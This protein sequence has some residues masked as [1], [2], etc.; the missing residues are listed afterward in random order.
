MQAIANILIVEDDFAI[1]ETI[2]ELL[3][4]EGYA[5]TRA[6]NGA[7]ALER[8]RRT[9]KTNVILLDLMMPVMDGWE[10]RLRQRS[11][12]GLASIPVVVLSADNALEQKVSNLGVEAWLP[13]PFE[14]E[15]LLET[16]GRL[17]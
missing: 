9:G 13:K 8:L 1:R 4:G 15:R 11:D 5:V 17:C 10:F 6:S 3:E 16:I 12:P 7:E 14:V 2:A